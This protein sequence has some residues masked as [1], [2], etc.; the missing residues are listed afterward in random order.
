MAAASQ[1]LVADAL[2]KKDSA[3]V[4]DISTTVFQ[5]SLYLGLGL[6]GLLQLGESSGFLFDIFTSDPLT[7]SSLSGI[8]PLIVLAQPISSLVFAADGV[9]QGASEFPFQARAMVLSGLTG[10][11]TFVALQAVGPDDNTLYHVWIALIALQVMRGLTSLYKI[12]EKD[13]PINILNN[14]K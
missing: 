5:Y 4:R 13:G 7:R 2:G 3:A 1:G 6:A 14:R 8:L 12:V 11:S 9:L 10:V